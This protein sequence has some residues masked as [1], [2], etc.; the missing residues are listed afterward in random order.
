MRVSPDF[1]DY[2]DN[3]KLKWDN[4]G[5]KR[6]G[7]PRTKITKHIA[8]EHKCIDKDDKKRFR[9]SFIK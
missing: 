3:L 4:M 1:K 5:G 2:V 7:I 6:K 8:D 9:F